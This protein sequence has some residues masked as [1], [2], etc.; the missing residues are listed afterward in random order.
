MLGRAAGPEPLD[1]LQIARLVGWSSVVIDVL[2]AGVLSCAELTGLIREL[3]TAVDRGMKV[4]IVST[5]RRLMK[6][7]DLTGVDVTVTGSVFDAREQLTSSHL[8]H[9]AGMSTVKSA[10]HMLSPPATIRSRS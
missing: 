10:A 4:S 7:V 8:N 9:T 6:V 1:A 3:R 2:A 5:D